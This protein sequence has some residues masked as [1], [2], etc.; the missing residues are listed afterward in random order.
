MPSAKSFR[1]PLLWTAYA[2]I[3]AAGWGLLDGVPTGLT[4]AVVLFVIWWTWWV[5]GR[6]PGRRTLVVLV[7]LKLV[8]GLGISIERGLEADYFANAQWAPP[9][10]RS[11]D[12]RSRSFT[13]I[14][15][16]LDFGG[17]GRPEF[18]L[19]FFNDVARFNSLQPGE[20]DRGD[21][22]FSVT[23]QGYVRAPRAEDRRQF[24]LRGTGVTAELW[25]DGAQTVHL[26][27][28]K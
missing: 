1:D 28:S 4:G 19:Y 5:R 3:P 8:A 11:T 10:E 7:L 15:R 16:Q 9:I 21:R 24:Y 23:W 22:P 18:P 2:L 17:P 27:P 14:D 25:V 20:P 26:V 12:F 13:R 6:L